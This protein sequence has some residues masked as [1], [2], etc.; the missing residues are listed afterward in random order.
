MELRQLKCFI[1]VAEE[2]NFRRASERL[3]VVQPTITV[4]IQRLERE[5]GTALFDRSTRPIS[6]TP[7]GSRLLPEAR[8]VLA[9]AERA[10]A[11]ARGEDR[12][13]EHM[14]LRLGTSHAMGSRLETVLRILG[15]RQP[16]LQVE[17]HDGP[18]WARLRQ[19]RENELD[20]TFIHMQQESPGL[21]MTTVWWDSLVIAL[22]AKSPLARRPALRL[23]DMREIP[24]RTVERSE[25]PRFFDFLWEHCREG[26]FEPVLGKPFTSVQNTLAEIGLGAPSWAVV[27]EGAMEGAPN[28]SVVSR[29][30]H[31]PLGVPVCVAVRDPACSRS[32][33]LLEA[34]WEAAR[35]HS[36]PGGPPPYLAAAGAMTG[37]Y[38]AHAAE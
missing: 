17:L 3:H 9:A 31:P 4:L 13:A 18:P 29:P 23:S 5:A 26:G 24:L 2:R 25:N 22:P 36:G 11:V 35:Q 12:K 37:A 15:E 30:I 20:A 1:A 27:Y 8:A 21:S 6:L 7:T 32:R 10:M 14:L 28:S 16:D 38:S 19:V 33:L 34:C